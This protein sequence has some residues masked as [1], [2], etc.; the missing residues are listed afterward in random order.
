MLGYHSE[1]ECDGF[2]DRFM[3]LDV[4]TASSAAA[5]RRSYRDR[6]KKWATADAGKLLS[7]NELRNR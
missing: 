4:R 2:T 3:S 1:D 7:V 6:H 5:A